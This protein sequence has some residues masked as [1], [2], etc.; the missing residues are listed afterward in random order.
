MTTSTSNFEFLHTEF[1]ALYAIGKEAEFLLHHDPAAT[2]AKLRVYG[3]K[4]VDQVFAQHQLPTPTENTQHNRLGELKRQGLLPRQVQD[5]LYLLKSKGNAAAHD[6]VGSLGDASLLLESAFHL[7]KW[8]L[9]TYAT[10]VVQAPETFSLPTPRDTHQELSQ[11]EAEKQ[12]LEQRVVE[13]QANLAAR[14]AYTAPQVAQLQQKSQQAADNLNLSEAETRAIIDQ[15]LQEVGWEADTLALRYNKDE[16]KGTRPQVGRNLAIA[17]WQTTS[18]PADY[19]LFVGMT[20]VGVVE[21]KRKNKDVSA[22]LLQSKRYAK[23]IKLTEGVALLK[24]APWGEYRAPFLFA[25]NG[26]PF[27]YQLPEKSGIW[28]LDGRKPTNHPRALRGWYTPEALIE[29]HK[30]DIEEAEAAL[31]ADRFDYLRAAHGLGLRDYQVTAIERVEEAMESNDPQRRALLA[32]ATGTGKTR[33]ILGLVYRLLKSNRYRRVLFLVD[34]KILGNQ[35]SESFN[36]VHIE[37]YQTL[38]Q[39]YDVKELKDR[40]PESETRLHVATVQ[41]LVKRIYYAEPGTPVLPV[42][43]YDCI[44]VDEAHRGYTLDREMSEPQITYKDQLDFLST[45]KLVLDYFDA[46]RVGLTATPAL[47]TVEIFG[48]PVFRYT[49]R[50]AVIDGF[51]IDHEPPIILKTKLNQEG[52]VWEAGSTPQ[53]FNP[54]TQTIEDLD[55]LADELKIEVEGFNKLVLTESFNR[56]VAQMLVK[57]LL[58]DG[59][60]K[61]LIFAASDQHADLLVRILKEEYREYGVEVDDD[62]II[63]I[64]GSADKPQQL[65]KRYKNELNPTIVVT[66]DLLTTGVDIPH[67]CNLVFLRRIRSRILYEQMLGRATRRADDIGKETFRIYDAVRLYEALQPVTTMKPVVVDPSQSIGDLIAE[68]E[69]IESPEAQQQQIEQILARLQRKR[70]KVTGKKAEDFAHKTNGQTLAQFLDH[71]RTL[72]SAEAAVVLK[73]HQAALS[74]VADIQGGGKPMLYSTHEDEALGTERGYGGEDSTSMQRP[75]D[76]L[77]AFETF[78]QGNKNTIA[79]LN[80]ICTNPQELTRSMLRDLKLALDEEGFTELQLSVAWKTVKKQDVGADIIGF[81]RSL[82]L[83]VAA[84]PLKARV[85]DAVDHVRNIKDWNPHQLKFLDRVQVQLL[86]EAVLTHDD[87]NKE[88]FKGEGGFNRYNKLF[89]NELDEVLHTIQQRLYVA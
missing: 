56:T 4:L 12:A 51:L 39:I 44:I 32:M 89:D 7:G 21:A 59:P 67:I 46:F 1:P 79:A 35:A 6:N 84:R 68:L 61:T 15:Q 54:E 58:P 69:H 71:V 3:E 31:K 17:E 60:E 23:D 10:G 64:T 63:K 43:T 75:E 36:D 77:H 49:Y 55:T 52:I 42:D 25:T 29:L 20:L 70:K 66:V 27:H 87:I 8:L 38:G 5:I 48:H 28:F 41:S 11:L 34:R 86:S 76:Y 26:R 37:S 80:I 74:W 53:A 47:H 57:Q 14:P 45:Y 65:V 24:G 40:L 16:T 82:V 50:Q 33:T 72:P 85:Q 18:G 88:P 2:L 30:Y 13:L 81:I 9:N 19:A 62:A 22:S 78:V 73:Q 83:G